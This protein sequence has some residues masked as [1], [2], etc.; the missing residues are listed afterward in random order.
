LNK[1]LKLS[2]FATTITNTLN[3]SSF[4]RTFENDNLIYLSS[5]IV[6]IVFLLYIFYKFFI[7]KSG[8]SG[9]IK[10]QK[11]VYDNLYLN[12]IIE[13]AIKE[14]NILSSCNINNKELLEKDIVNKLTEANIYL[15]TITD[16]IETNIENFDLEE[17]INSMNYTFY[18]K[19]HRKEFNIVTNSNLAYSVIADKTILKDIFTLLALLQFKEHNLNNA[20]VN[21]DL[22]KKDNILLI[23]VTQGLDYN[24]NIQKALKNDLNPIYDSKQKKYYGIYLY[25][26]NRLA[27]KINGVLKIDILKN[28]YKVK[29]TIPV[30]IE[31]LENK[32]N[33]ILPKE[34]N[35]NKK[36]L[37]VCEDSNLSESIENF[38]NL[39][40]ISADTIL[41]DKII[42]MPNFKNYDIL[43]S[44]SSL[45]LSI[46]S[47]YL[48][49]IKSK[50]NLKIVSIEAPDR[51]YKYQRTLVDFKLKK[52]VLQ[53][54]IY[55]M[56]LHIYHD[57]IIKQYSNKKYEPK[58]KK[59]KS[60]E[61]SKKN[62]LNSNF[63]KNRKQKKQNRV[64]IADDDR[65]NRHLLKKMIEQFNIEVIE[66]TNGQEALDILNKEKNFDLIILDS[67]MPKRT[68]YDAI[69]EIRANEEYNSIPVIIHS[70]FSMQEQS[71]DSIF[72]LGFDSY[73]P[74]PFNMEKL[75][76]ILQRYLQISNLSIKK[77]KSEIKKY[78]EEFIAIYANSDKLLEKFVSEN[79]KS[80]LK[81]L[82]RDL[83]N[84]SI[85]IEDTELTEAIIDVEE[86]LK[87]NIDVNS[88]LIY[89]LI[90][91]IRESKNYILSKLA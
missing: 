91:Q 1:I 8:K 15:N 20:T 58:K 65:V 34:F 83:K 35:S 61:S 66:A 50:F 12:D 79:Q 51:E 62:L 75:Q 47:D 19:K 18:D 84:I 57:E 88:D 48:V 87:E 39:Y 23:K 37:I 78:Y 86:K 38:L 70:S 27:N 77:K 3:A 30:N 90:E 9:R 2:I 56:I 43:I 33:L 54:K 7:K 85:K 41:D 73:L 16:Q 52:P 45:L 82:L 14:Y 17:F 53:S 59:P 74:K 13:S 24:E 26:I 55:Q 4:G 67:M 21:I 28:T 72:K 10:S 5:I 42:Q 80:Q 68:A 6:I 29:L 25:L 31:H 64:L 40:N 69:K 81:S 46:L 11:N 60:L 71:I 76:S 63:F 36:A 44:N 32:T 22:V 49:T 89:N